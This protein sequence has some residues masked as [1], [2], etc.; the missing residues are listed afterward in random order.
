MDTNTLDQINIYGAIC[1]LAL[2][3]ITGI[4]NLIKR[5][6]YI[7]LF[8]EIKNLSPGPNLSLKSKI[9]TYFN[10]QTEF[11]HL[12]QK[13]GIIETVYHYI[14]NFFVFSTII[15]VCYLLARYT[16]VGSLSLA[17]EILYYI[18]S[19]IEAFIL[20]M[21]VI[22][23]GECCGFNLSKLN[24]YKKNIKSKSC[25]I[26]PFGGSKL[27]NK[28]IILQKVLENAKQIFK[29]KNIILLHNGKKND[30]GE[31]QQSLK[32][33]CEKYN[34][35]Y[36]Y[37]PVGSKSY[38]IYYA[39]NYLCDKY[40]Y[41]MVIDDDVILPIDL[42]LP[43]DESELF[44]IWAFMICAE[45]PE[46]TT[47]FLS[48]MLVY[49]QDVEYRFSGFIKFLQ[50]RYG[51][52]STLSHHGAIS[53]YDKNTLRRVMDK[54]DGVFDGEDLLMGIIAYNSGYKM[55]TLPDQY[56]PTKTPD[57]FYDFYRQRVYSWDY[58]ILK[59][60]PHYFKILFNFDFNNLILKLS[61]LYNIWTII[62]DFTRIPN[63][64]ILSVFQKTNM[65]I[66]IYIAIG[67]FCKSF[68]ILFILFFRN[69]YN[70]PKIPIF[71][72]LM[73]VPFFPIYSAITY[74]FRIIAQ[75]KY[76][77]FYDPKIKNKIKLKDR[78][79][80]PNLLRYFKIEEIEWR[81]IY[82]LENVPN[83]KELSFN[84]SPQNSNDSPLKYFN[85]DIGDYTI[86]ENRI[87]ILSNQLKNIED[88]ISNLICNY[89]C[90][91]IIPEMIPKQ[92]ENIYGG[93]GEY[94]EFTLEDFVI[95]N[96]I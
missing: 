93:I 54:H 67:L 63:L 50:S 10:S 90:D 94:T 59:F 47:N 48:K 82:D 32:E 19:G 25:L 2:L 56:V 27:E 3:L 35:I 41:I 84:F 4:T 53:F 14:F 39:C 72:G 64:I 80:L 6:L 18:I 16:Y 79:Q 52:L 30:P 40:D 9:T 34:T 85:N 96:K 62:Q 44:K 28:M 89:E 5:Y 21:S 76:L 11:M 69:S 38:S 7:K 78:P 46:E 91:I 71:Y 70:A 8:K 15:F 87:N 29:K 51:T 45:P 17:I 86:L 13:F 22:N 61:S 31:I 77:I 1:C 75:F 43:H 24:Y 23:I 92:H 65:W 26:I 95:P 66:G 74:L 20:F 58:V 68:G 42:K 57:N 12:S 83:K 37:I 49:C 60:I 33:L 55:K 81:Q 36:T 88:K 73:L